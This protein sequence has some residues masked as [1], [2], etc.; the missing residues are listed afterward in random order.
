MNSSPSDPAVGRQA[1]V[2]ILE[3]Y[4][5][6]MT[7][8]CQRALVILASTHGSSSLGEAAKAVGV[9]EA[10]KL[11]VFPGVVGPLLE[12]GLIRPV[13][14]NEPV[15][16]ASKLLLDARYQAVADN[17]ALRTWLFTSFKPPETRLSVSADETAVK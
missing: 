13:P 9:P 3:C 5:E 14:S 11:H 10:L 17:N 15:G 4:R 16:S 2:A 8:A 7:R 6:S 1:A 12:L